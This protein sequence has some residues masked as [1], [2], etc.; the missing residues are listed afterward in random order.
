MGFGR[1]GKQNLLS[2]AIVLSDYLTK[3]SEKFKDQWVYLIG[4]ENLKT[5]LEEC[6]EVKVFGTGPDHKDDYTDGDFIYEVDV[7]TRKPKAVVVSFDSHFRWDLTQ[8]RPETTSVFQ[9]P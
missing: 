3:N 7:E 9:L 8:S 5:T 6:G 1:L 2:P 4:V